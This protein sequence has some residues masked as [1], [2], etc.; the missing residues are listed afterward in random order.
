MK[1]NLLLAL[2]LVCSAVLY[3]EE[4]PDGYYNSINGKKD[5]EL[6]TALSQIIGKGQRY[7]YG[8]QDNGNHTEDKVDPCTGETLWKEGDPRY[9]TWNA[10]AT[11]DL[12]SDGTIWDM[13]SNIKRYLPIHGGSA[14]SVDIE[15][16]LPKSWWG[17]ESGCL[18]AYCDLY[19]LNPADHLTNSN[20]SNY[21]PGILID[22][23]KVNNGV[24]FMGKDATWNDFAFDVC[25]DYKGDFAR[26][27]FYTAT[28][29][30]NVSWV[31]NYSKYINNDSYLSF[32]PYLVE[33]LLA[34]HRKDPVSEKEVDRLNAI[35]DI[36]HNRNAFIEYPELVEYIWGNKQ[37]Q[38]VNL[39][40]LTRTTDGNYEFPISATN[41]LAHE[42]TEIM[43][44]SF[45]AHWSN[46]GS[47]QYEL[48]VFTR[49][50]SGHNDTL[51]AIH[52]MN[53]DAIRNH[54][55]TLTYHKANGDQITT[56]QGITDGGYAITMGT[57]SEERYFLIKNIDF[58]QQGAELIVKCAISRNDKTPQKMVVSADGNEIKTVTLSANDTFPR[59]EIPKGTQQIKVASVKK[60]RISVHKMFIIRG[61]YKVTETSVAGFPVSVNDLE[62]LVKTP[63]DEGDILY[64]RV[65]PAGLRATNTVK[66]V[67][68]GQL[69]DPQ[70]GLED[71]YFRTPVHKELREGK[72]II[73]RD[74]T[75]YTVLGQQI[76]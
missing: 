48:D 40:Q 10:F 76:R 50:E 75:S 8:S 19:L 54:T 49:V 60:N 41:P 34:W 20:K 63:F 16:S 69:P 58:S 32:T 6:K 61:D 67:G 3:A 36:Q 56:T 45:M 43:K 31:S 7:K 29:Y 11:T 9:G 17:G 53:T 14:A 30:E 47:E 73:V 42:A 27:Y 37:G 59:F 70:E 28:A 46:T 66:V 24:F 33:V 22:S 1:K 13:Y 62:Y 35:S 74:N 55:D 57:A 23:T 38:K 51:F 72:I 64:Y 25:D 12:E 26:A 52:G 21:P 2:A 18:S 39:S 44:D 15:H 65:K 68:N 5:A 4:M 71:P